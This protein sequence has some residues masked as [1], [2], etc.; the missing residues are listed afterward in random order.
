MLRDLGEVVSGALTESTRGGS[1]STSAGVGVGLGAAGN[2]SYQGFNFGALLGVSGGYG[3]SNSSAWQDSAKN[4]A[5][6][7]LQ[8]L[9]DRT[10]LVPIEYPQ[11]ASAPLALAA[12]LQGAAALA[13]VSGRVLFA[14]PRGRSLELLVAACAPLPLPPGR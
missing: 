13:A 1:K 14:Q 4:V 12:D 7:S 8:N 2:G 11:P 9:R 5:S 6:S 3:E 10:L